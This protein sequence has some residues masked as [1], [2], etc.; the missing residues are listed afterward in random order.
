MG[1]G[2]NKE[3]ERVRAKHSSGKRFEVKHHGRAE[4]HT[5]LAMWVGIVEQ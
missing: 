5:K 2:K 1:K 4:F 3:K